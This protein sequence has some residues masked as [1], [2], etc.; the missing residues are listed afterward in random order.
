[1]RTH[2][3]ERVTFVQVEVTLHEDAG[4]VLDRPKHQAALMTHD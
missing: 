2:L 1:M 3:T 4:S